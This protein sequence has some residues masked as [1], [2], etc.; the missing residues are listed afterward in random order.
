VPEGYFELAK[1]TWNAT[2]SGQT[3]LGNAIRTGTPAVARDI[4]REAGPQS[5]RDDALRCGFGSCV[6]LALR[7]DDRVIGA[8]VIYAEEADAFGDEEVGLLSEAAA[9]LSF[10]IASQ[11]AELEPA[12]MKESEERLRPAAEAARMSQ[13]PGVVE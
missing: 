12:R 3:P 11:R 7:I 1:F 10:R 6:A 4:Q 13:Q 9:D 2:E 5:W 8:L